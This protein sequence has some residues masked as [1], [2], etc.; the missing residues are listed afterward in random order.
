M[1]KQIN[2]SGMTFEV[3][4]DVLY[5]MEKSALVSDTKYFKTPEFV[6][7]KDERVVV[8]EAKTSVPRPESKEDFKKYLSE[9]REKFSNALSLLNACWSKRNLAELSNMPEKLQK[10]TVIGADYR[11]YLIVATAQEEWL[12]NVNNAFKSELQ[13][14]FKTWNIQDTAFKAITKAKA[15]QLGLVRE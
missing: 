7:L 10:I 15:I 12:V 6:C 8:I 2:E 1:M 9:I 11:L 13:I 14:L 4:E 3:D 5:H